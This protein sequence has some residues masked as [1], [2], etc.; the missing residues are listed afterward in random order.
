ML[1]KG[2]IYPP[3]SPF[4][5]MRIHLS[6]PFKSSTASRYRYRV[7]LCRSLMTSQSDKMPYTPMTEAE[8]ARYRVSGLSFPLSLF[9]SR[10]L[11]SR[12]KGK[13][14]DTTLWRD[15]LVGRTDIRTSKT[16]SPNSTIRNH[17]ITYPQGAKARLMRM[18]TRRL[19]PP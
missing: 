9:P 17:H 2:Y 15:S 6:L 18:T 14:E 1:L 10:I 11:G 12:E 5:I 7:H 13:M 16:S 19:N 4:F 3:N 8:Q